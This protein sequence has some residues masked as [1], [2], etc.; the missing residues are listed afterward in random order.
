MEY[1]FEEKQSIV[2]RYLELAQLSFDDALLKAI[3]QKVDSVPREIFNLCIKIRD[4]CVHNATHSLNK[5]LWES[6]LKHSNIQDGGMTSLHQQ[7]LDVL[8]YYDRPL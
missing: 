7:Y 6:F 1:T 3:A 2:K 8:S 4:F 5:Q